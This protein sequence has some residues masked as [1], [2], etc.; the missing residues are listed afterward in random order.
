VGDAVLAAN[1]AIVAVRAVY[2][3]QD[4]VA[5]EFECERWHGLRDLLVSELTRRRDVA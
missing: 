2:Q 3:A 5:D 4:K 1:K